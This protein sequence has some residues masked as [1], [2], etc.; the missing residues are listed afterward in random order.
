[1]NAPQIIT[2][3]LFCLIASCALAVA[4]AFAQTIT[5]TSQST[6]SGDAADDSFG[7][8]VSGA[9]DVNGDGFDDVIVGARLDGN[10]G[11]SSGTARVF[12]GADGSIL[13]FIFEGDST[14][15]EFGFSVSDAGDVNGDGFADLIVG[16]PTNDN[17]RIDLS[18]SARVFSGVDG[19]VLYTFDGDSP[20]NFGSS[21]SGA[22]DVNGDGLA[23]FI[24]GAA[25]G[26]AN[27]A[28]FARVFVSQITPP[29]LGDADQ[30]GEVTFADI[31]PFIEVLSSGEFQAEADCNEDGEVNFSDIA[32]FI[33]LLAN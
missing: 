17:N 32:A 8:S 19:S 18:G 12:S 2:H 33:I 20:V 5:H 29:T 30:D 7:H 1:M 13:N 9:G 4:P 27:N 11:A 21:V 14:G 25:F 31:A 6:F 26:G 16:A 28:G 10:N 3:F 23:D 22:G 15:D 24:I